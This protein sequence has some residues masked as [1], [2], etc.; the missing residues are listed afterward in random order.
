MEHYLDHG[1]K[2]KTTQPGNNVEIA[3]EVWYSICQW[4]ITQPLKMIT[5]FVSDNMKNDN[6]G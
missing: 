2:L 4:T 5:N 1:R 6:I 3:K